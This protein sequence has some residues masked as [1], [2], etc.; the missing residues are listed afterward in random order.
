MI[1]FDSIGFMT[2]A[3]VIVQPNNHKL[4]KI[5]TYGVAAFTIMSFAADLG[6]KMY[7]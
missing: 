7:F 2:V 1:D 4:V 6:M 3:N 5:M